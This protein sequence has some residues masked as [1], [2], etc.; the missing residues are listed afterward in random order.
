M[1]TVCVCASL[2]LDR[3]GYN[4]NS[5]NNNNPNATNKEPNQQETYAQA[6]ARYGLPTSQLALGLCAP[7][8]LTANRRQ[9][10]GA[11]TANQSQV[12]CPIWAL[13]MELLDA[14]Q[15]Q[16]RD[17]SRHDHLLGPPSSLAY[18]LAPICAQ[19]DR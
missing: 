4:S 10:T 11:K 14:S 12:C 16:P 5:N 6:Q 1:L 19:P 8:D 3:H 7:S 2:H 18:L 9:P 13:A 15:A 17:Q